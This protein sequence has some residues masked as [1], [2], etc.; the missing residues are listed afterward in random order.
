MLVGTAV[1][2][3]SDVSPAAADPASPT[4][5]ESVI[6]SISAEGYGLEAAI[7]GGD[8][9]ISL[10]VH[11]S[12]E[13][14]VLGYED[15]PY[16]RFSTDGTVEENTRSPAVALNRTRFGGSVDSDS[17][18]KALPEW[19]VVATNS[20]YV[21]HD[22]RI[23]W[24]VR[25]LPPQLAGRSEG[26]VLDWSVPLLVGDKPVTISGELYRRTPPSVVPYVAIGFVVT[27]AAAVA[28]RRFRGGAAALL[29]VVALLAFTLSLV[30]QLSIPA[31]AGRRVSLIVIPALAG[32]CT[33]AALGRPRSVYALALKSACALIMPLWIM[34]N[35]K[36]LSN[37]RLPGDVSPVALRLTLVSATAIV[38]A[39]AAIDLPRE[40]RLAAVLP[41]G[42]YRDAHD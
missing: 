14:I 3:A 16:V 41:L 24:M 30:E 29:L 42:R 2:L 27:A 10:R 35:A 19:R 32:V 7:V 37:A 21:W 12:G 1:A 20:S 13:V 23:H 40:L 28:M 4:N 38:V 18:A 17:D 33:L 8:S 15:E 5:Y 11:D 31:A 25:S 6:T 9:F 22:H 26:K 36:A 34:L 39:F